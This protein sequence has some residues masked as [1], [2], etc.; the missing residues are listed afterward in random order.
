VATDLLDDLERSG[1]APEMR[2]L[3]LMGVAIAPGEWAQLR[4]VLR[5]ARELGVDRAWVDE[6]LLQA[7]LFFGFPRV[8]TAFGALREEWPAPQVAS[9]GGGAARG[10]AARGGLAAERWEAA[11]RDLFRRI[12]GAKDEAVRGMLESYHPAFHDFVLDAAYGRVLSRPELDVGRREL[13]AVGWL[14]A[15]HQEPQAVAHGRGALAVGAHRDEV[16]EAL[17]S[18]VRDARRAREWMARIERA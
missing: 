15:L 17:W 10:G 12:Y 13:L 3:V 6:A 4:R 16:A 2:V 18:G 14:G 11:G 7:V 1:L 9:S 8:V 5:R